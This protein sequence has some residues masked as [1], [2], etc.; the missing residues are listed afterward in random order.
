MA[1]SYCARVIDRRADRA[2]YRQLADIL[3]TR[4]EDGTYGPG[5]DLPSLG[6]LCRDYNVGREVVRKALAILE[7]A[8]LIDTERGVPPRVREPEVRELVHVQRGSHLRS[9]PPTLAEQAELRMQDGVDVIEIRY[10][11]KVRVYPADRFDFYV[12]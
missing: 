8:G 5:D 4:I 3:R 2:V 11:A 7:T 6:I 9:R 10:G 12:P 1:R